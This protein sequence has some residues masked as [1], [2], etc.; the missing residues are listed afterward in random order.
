MSTTPL[1]LG[2][3]GAPPTD[4]GSSL[5][6]GPAA[7]G[8]APFPLT[9]PG[10]GGSEGGAV[11]SDSTTQPWVNGFFSDLFGVGTELGVLALTSSSTP[12]VAARTPTS[13]PAVLG[14]TS[15]AEFTLLIVVGVGVVLLAIVHHHA[16]KG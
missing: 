10:F 13:T 8:T 14:A 3:L 2:S 4:F 9:P 12:N 11:N 6:T 1:D 5:D 16:H 7:P 15:N